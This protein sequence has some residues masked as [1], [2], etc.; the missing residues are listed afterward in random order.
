MRIKSFN[1]PTPGTRHFALGTLLF[2]LSVL[3]M[4]SCDV[5]QFPEMDEPDPLPPIVEEETV[6]VPLNLIFSPD[7][8]VWEY[9]YDP[10]IGKI[11]EL[12]PES[13]IY[14]DYPGTTS[15]YDNTLGSGVID[16]HLKAYIASSGRLVKEQDFSFELSET[17]YNTTCVLEL[18][19]DKKYNIGV[20]GH[21]REHSEAP[22]YYDP[23]DFNKV[24]IISSSY[25]GNTDYRD[26]FSGM[27]DIDTSVAPTSA[28]KI[29]MTRPMGKFEFVT[30]DLSEFLDR[31]TSRRSLST[32]ATPEE[33]NVVV[34]YPYYYPSS[35][36]LL[37]DRNENS[38][39]GVSF[40]TKM[41]VT[42]D[43]E[44]SLG[45]DYVMLSGLPGDAV[46]TRVDIY[47]PANTHV[48]GSII[49]TVP[50][51][52]DVHTVLRGAFLSEQ[53]EGGVG[54]DP[55]FEGDFNIPL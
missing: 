5:H 8:Y 32:R 1:H 19:V 20:W 6:K 12:Y 17:G 10:K 26:G 52:R 3:L 7:F 11:Q 25:K 39:A 46:Q 15:R 30:I 47:D 13:M 45:F 33:Y 50:M 4:T 35:Y 43:S 31:E 48:A 49:L 42:G 44:A 53:N 51:K 18:P 23:S 16:V 28:M 14:P 38:R 37:D 54:I 41:T 55:D 36:S 24:E 34:S 9:S 21:F 40:K 22:A 29:D 2:A 27:V